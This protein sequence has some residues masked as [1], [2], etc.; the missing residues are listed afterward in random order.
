MIDVIGSYTFKNPRRNLLLI[1]RCFTVG[2][3]IRRCA[4]EPRY[5]LQHVLIPLSYD[6]EGSDDEGISDVSDEGEELSADGEGDE[7]AQVVGRFRPCLFLVQS[8][9]CFMVAPPRA[10]R[11]KVV[12]ADQKGK[13]EG[14][15]DDGGEEDEEENEGDEDEDEVDDEEDEKI[16][17]KPKVVA[18]APAAAADDDGE[19]HVVSDGDGDSD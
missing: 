16:P 1:I 19:G 14:D 7:E 18:K 2:S 17:V 3:L 9:N 13:A 6:D 5:F 15:H 11:R 10:K 8:V 4:D 12:A